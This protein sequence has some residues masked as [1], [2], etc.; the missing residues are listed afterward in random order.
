MFQMRK[1][2]MKELLASGGNGKYLIEETFHN[3]SIGRGGNVYLFHYL[4]LVML[5]SF[6]KSKET[7][8]YYV[9]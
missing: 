5:G 2:I 1:S 3:R 9:F 7:G 8:I 6:K 4:Q